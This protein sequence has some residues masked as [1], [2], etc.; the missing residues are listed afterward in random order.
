VVQVAFE[1]QISKQS[2]QSELAKGNKA[3]GDL[4]PWSVS[5]QYNDTD[6]AGLSGARIVRIATHP[7]VQ[8]LGYGSR[9]MDLLISYFQ[10]DLSDNSST[11]SVGVFGGESSQSAEEEAADALIEED[12]LPRKKL[13]P[14]LTSLS[15]RPAERLHWIGVSFG[16]TGQLLNFW[17]RKGMKMCYL[18]QTANDLTGEHSA[19]MLCE[20]N[21]EGIEDAPAP[22]WLRAYVKDYRRRI[23]TMLA[24]SFR[25]LD[26]AVALTLVDPDKELG[27]T[28]ESTTRVY[29]ETPL[30][31]GELL[32]VHMSQHD[33]ARLELYSRNMVDH[34]MIVDILPTISRLYFLGRMPSVHLS[35]L[36]MAILLATGLQHRDA[37]DVT[38]ELNL[39]ANQVLAFFNKTI[40]KLATHLRALVER[41][42]A[43]ELPSESMIKKFE[44]KAGDMMTSRIS[45]KEDQDAD[46]VNFKAQQ[47]K[48]LLGLKDISKHALTVEEDTLDATM[49][50]VSKTNKSIP[51]TVSFEVKVDAGDMKRKLDDVERNVDNGGERRKKKKSH[52]NKHRD[53]TDEDAVVE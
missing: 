34:H 7:D 33:L 43:K 15:E 18:R 24:Y 36:Q 42:V 29:D 52:K 26:T 22:G 11:L 1:G 23:V 53:R 38:R 8:K 31:T 13:P 25:H 49:L 4:I 5:Q 27:S 51:S 30:E 39:P 2:I 3:S 6:F 47:R 46:E 35:A 10:G 9:A 28:T 48:L 12:V 37:D 50:R 17:S 32:S 20:L 16:L 19:V 41:Q 45:L 14:L 21:C 44:K 40:R